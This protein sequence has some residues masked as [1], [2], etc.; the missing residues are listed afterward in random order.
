MKRWLFQN[1]GLK[2][3]SLIIAFALWAYVGSRQVLE[4]RLNVQLE[5]S[6]MPVG[7][8]LDPNLKTNISV[9]L[10]GRKDRI[11]D[12]DPEDLSALVSLRGAQPGQKEIVVHPKIQNLPIGVTANMADVTLHLIPLVDNSTKSKKKG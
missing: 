5:F 10:I 9:N 4:Q 11:L 6:D 3:L 7:M 12:I 8:T 2:F 1:M